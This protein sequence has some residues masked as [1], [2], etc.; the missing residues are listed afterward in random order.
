MVA[1][2][3]FFKIMISTVILNAYL[4]M[5]SLFPT[6]CKTCEQYK[7]DLFL[8]ISVV[9]HLS[10]FCSLNT[11]CVPGI[12]HGSSDTNENKL[13]PARTLSAAEECRKI[14]LSKHN[15]IL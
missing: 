13:A 14:F 12:P 6:A 10:N 8:I 5:P 1:Y 7:L 4:L 2:I 3:I 9:I 11:C 15:G